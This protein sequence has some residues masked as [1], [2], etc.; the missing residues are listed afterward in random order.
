MRHK[1]HFSF[2]LCQSDVTARKHAPAAVSDTVRCAHDVF[3]LT[4]NGHAAVTSWKPQ[5]WL[6]RII[7]VCAPFKGCWSTIALRCD[8]CWRPDSSSDMEGCMARSHFACYDDNNTFSSMPATN[9][10]KFNLSSD[11]CVFNTTA[12]CS[13]VCTTNLD[14]NA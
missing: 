2:P 6:G 1:G 8:D 7:Y 4:G 5:F 3:E 13:S 10:I 14:K 11:V 12:Q 9:L